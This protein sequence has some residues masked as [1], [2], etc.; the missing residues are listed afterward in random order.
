M[1]LLSPSAAQADLP[2]TGIQSCGPWRAT[3]GEYLD[4]EAGISFTHAF[5]DQHGGGGCG[6]HW[7]AMS[8]WCLYTADKEDRYLS[9][10]R[11]AGAGLLPEPR[12][13]AAF[14]DFRL[15]PAGSGSSEQP[16]YRQ[17]G[18]DF[19]MLRGI[20]KTCG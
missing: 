19:P 13:V 18:Q 11:W 9:G 5:P 17:E 2:V 3:D 7:A 15:D 10:G 8:G 4:V 14:V 20:V 16:Y 12:L 6:L 1:P